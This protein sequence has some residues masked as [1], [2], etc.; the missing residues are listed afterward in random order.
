LLVLGGELGLCGSYNARAAEAGRAKRQELGPGPTL[1]VGRRTGSLLV[2]RGVSLDR[3]HSAPTSTRGIHELLLRLAEEALERY[4]IEGWSS[5]SI[6]YLSYGGVGSDRPECS[7][8]L[9]LQ[10]HTSEP[11]PVRRYVDA[12]TFAAVSVRELLYVSLYVALLDALASEQAARLVATQSA[13][14]WLHERLRELRRR[15]ASA[16]REAST[17]EML[18]IAAGVQVIRKSRARDA[19]QRAS[20]SRRT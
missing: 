12:Q 19:H 14:Q 20:R 2:R 10:E 1:C 6:V 9:P 11:V 4:T 17:Q 18:E 3:T 16:S 15:L 13:E 8:L 7:Q 5:L